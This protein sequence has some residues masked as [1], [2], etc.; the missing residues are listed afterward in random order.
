[1]SAR[2]DIWNL[3]QGNARILL[4]PKAS[5]AY[6]VEDW[7]IMEHTGAPTKRRN[8]IYDGLE[9]VIERHGVRMPETIM[10]IPS[11]TMKR[12]E[13]DLWSEQNYRLVIHQS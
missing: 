5:T 8:D 12:G 1:V 10:C 6:S 11:Q 4:A 2:W 13:L 7:E 9:E 3:Q